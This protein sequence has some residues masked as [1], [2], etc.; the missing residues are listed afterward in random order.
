MRPSVYIHRLCGRDF[1][2]VIRKD[3][4]LIVHVSLAQQLQEAGHLLER[5]VSVVVALDEQYRRLPAARR[6]DAGFEDIRVA[7]RGL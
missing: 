4:E 6:V 1:V 2:H 3:D 5:H 7:R